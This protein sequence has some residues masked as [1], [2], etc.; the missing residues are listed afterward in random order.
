MATIAG[1]GLRQMNKQNAQEIVLVG[2][3]AL[4]MSACGPRRLNV[5]L[6]PDQTLMTVAYSADRSQSIFKAD[7]EAQ[8]YCERRHKTVMFIKED[9]LYQGRYNEDVTA[10]ARTAG[11]VAGA[12]GSSKAA[13]ASR[14]VSSPT[15]YKT[16]FEFTCK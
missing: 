6:T 15:D 16:T 14:A 9:T 5:M 1:K 3:L 10:A 7:E 11:R 12:L 2:L 8:A 13:S 4:S